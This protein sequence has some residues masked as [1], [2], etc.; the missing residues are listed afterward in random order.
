[1]RFRKNARRPSKSGLTPVL[2]PGQNRCM[3]I[4]AALAIAFTLTSKIAAAE[5]PVAVVISVQGDRAL[6]QNSQSFDLEPSDLIRAGDEIQTGADGKVS[7]QSSTGV[8]FQIGSLSHV[9]ITD[10]NQT[11]DSSVL[12]VDLKTGNIATIVSKTSGSNSVRIQAPTAAAS[13]RGTEFLVEA[14]EEETSVS[15]GDGE[16]EVEDAGGTK[17]RVRPGGVIRA[18]LREKL[19]EERIDA[20]RAER[21]KVFG[22][23][24][25]KRDE[26]FR[27][28]VEKLRNTKER[29]RKRREFIRNLRE[30]RRDSLKEAR[31]ERKKR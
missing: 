7:V 9:K 19:R 29:I 27:E 30:A 25:T 20:R 31:E 6:I 12:I 1:M 26:K 28:R 17:A 2:A 24:R 10:M 13:V 3:R 14:D 8:I 4:L 15:V 18:R 21:L 16:V 23:F 11:S 22:E 5:K